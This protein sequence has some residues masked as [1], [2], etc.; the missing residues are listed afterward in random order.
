MLNDLQDK[1]WSKE[2][3]EK[4]NRDSSIDER[5]HQAIKLMHFL[6]LEYVKDFCQYHPERFDHS[7][8]PL[9][10]I[11][12]YENGEIIPNERFLKIIATNL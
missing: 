5:Y 9:Q 4:W 7:F 8:Y 10:E 1:V 2:Q 6:L 3:V 11:C 12:L